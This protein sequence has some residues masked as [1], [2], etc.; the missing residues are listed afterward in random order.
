MDTNI[1]LCHQML[2][3]AG[4]TTVVAPLLGLLLANSARALL[5]VCP[6]CVGW[7]WWWWEWWVAQAHLSPAA[8]SLCKRIASTSPMNSHPGLRGCYL[9]SCCMFF[10]TQGPDARAMAFWILSCLAYLG[11]WPG[12]DVSANSFLFNLTTK[13][14]AIT[15]MPSFQR[16]LKWV[17][18]WVVI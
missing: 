18:G 11:G 13:K 15:A 2:M 1:S 4:K 17:L 10:S 14:H 9:L 12:G 8:H 7:W 3:G 6:C 5:Q 16:T